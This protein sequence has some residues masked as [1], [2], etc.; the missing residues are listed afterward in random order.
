MPYKFIDFH[1]LS[2]FH[3]IMI[4]FV[5]FENLTISVSYKTRSKLPMYL[6][7]HCLCIVLEFVN[8]KCSLVTMRKFFTS[9][10]ETV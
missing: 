7:V 8:F 3:C 2:V 5:L 10:I 1:K 4:T 6:N 9:T